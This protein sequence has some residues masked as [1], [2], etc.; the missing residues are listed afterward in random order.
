MFRYRYIYCGR[1]LPVIAL[2]IATSGVATVPELV[3]TDLLNPRRQYLALHPCSGPNAK[4][5]TA[6]V[7]FTSLMHLFIK[8]RG[9]N[10]YYFEIA[11]ATRKPS[12]DVGSSIVRY[13]IP[14]PA[15]L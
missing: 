5:R 8:V 1:L 2:V 6:L 4:T 12:A 13:P 7:D 11:V 15:E 14:G 9:D 3:R 10:F